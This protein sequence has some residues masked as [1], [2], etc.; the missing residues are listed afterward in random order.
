MRDFRKIPGHHGWLISK[1]A[2]RFRMG[3]SF[4]ERPQ[5]DDDKSDVFFFWC[6]YMLERAVYLHKCEL[7][8]RT[9]E[10]DPD[11]DPRPPSEMPVAA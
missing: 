9:L 8:K 2:L 11:D 1:G 10:D 7:V 4:P 3:L 6:G 5:D